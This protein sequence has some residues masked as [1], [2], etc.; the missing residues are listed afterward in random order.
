MAIVFHFLDAPVNEAILAFH[1]GETEAFIGRINSEYAFLICIHKFF[2]ELA[3]AIARNASA[4][5]VLLASGL[6]AIAVLI[7]RP[8]RLDMAF[9]AF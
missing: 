6:A 2:Q 9:F 3:L 7:R 8:A 4:F 5:L 1:N